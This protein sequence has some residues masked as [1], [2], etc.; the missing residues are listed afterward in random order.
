VTVVD[1]CVGCKAEDID[2][3]TSV[4]GELAEIGQGRVKAEWAWL[5]SAPVAVPT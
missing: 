2:T 4:F 3:T 5:E 1:R